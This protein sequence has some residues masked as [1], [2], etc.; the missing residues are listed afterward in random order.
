[1]E[2]IKLTTKEKELLIISYQIYSDEL[3]ESN[4]LIK[5]SIE[6]LKKSR[7]QRRGKYIYDSAKKRL[8]KNVQSI[9]GDIN[10][11]IVKDPHNRIYVGGHTV[12]INNNMIHINDRYVITY[13]TT[14]Y[15]NGFPMN[16][17]LVCKDT[18]CEGD[19][20]KRRSK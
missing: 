14:K 8:I 11:K 6:M 17:S 5:A 12:Q 4:R 19:N 20:F 15:H 1:M 9:L 10:N 13:E 18:I 7:L 3:N 2:E 16:L